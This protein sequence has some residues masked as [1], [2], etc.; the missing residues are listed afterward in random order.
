MVGLN[1]NCGRFMVQA[2]PGKVTMESEVEKKIGPK[3]CPPIFFSVFVKTRKTVPLAIFSIDDDDAILWFGGMA[4]DL[5][6]YETTR[7]GGFA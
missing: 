7:E 3:V 2:Y 4:V 5:M 1:I 6:R